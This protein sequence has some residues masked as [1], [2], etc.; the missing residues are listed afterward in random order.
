M[1]GKQTQTLRAEF[2]FKVALEAIKEKQ[3]MSELTAK[4]RVHFT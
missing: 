4:F 3:T 1:N 2:R